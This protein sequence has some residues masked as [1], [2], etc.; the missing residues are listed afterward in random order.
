MT[1]QEIKQR[2]YDLLFMPFEEADRLHY[3]DK[4]PRILNEALFRIAHSVLPNL[5]EYTIKISQNKMPARISMPPDFISFADE[6]NAYLNG[7]PFC[8]TNFIGNNEI[9]LFGN[10][11]DDSAYKSSTLNESKVNEYHIFYNA[12]Y[13]K[14]TN[15]GIEFQVIEFANGDDIPVNSDNYSI[16]TVPAE[17]SQITGNKAYDLPSIVSELIPHYIAGQLLVLDD[18][19]RSIEEM[20][21]FETLLAAIN[22]HRN[23]RPRE[24]HSAKGWY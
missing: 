22:T 21:E 13:P 14:L 3:T 8:L 6:Q 20:N 1:Y 4:I 11:V 16:V 19:V 17:S 12:L 9:L 15:S 5:R 2:V 23:E 24:Y 7:K 18:K 10:E